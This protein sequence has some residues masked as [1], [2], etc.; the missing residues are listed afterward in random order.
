MVSSSE[1]YDDTARRNVRC[2]SGLFVGIC[3]A[4]NGTLR[5][6]KALNV[7]FTAIGTRTR[8]AARRDPEC[9]GAANRSDES[10]A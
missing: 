2:A 8:V 9:P 6:V 7:P 1:Q 4:V 10:A 3:K 5:A